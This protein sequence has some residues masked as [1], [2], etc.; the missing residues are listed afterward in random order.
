MT[1]ETV[2][3]SIPYLFEYLAMSEVEQKRWSYI[4]EHCS[5]INPHAQTRD[6]IINADHYAFAMRMH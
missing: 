6:V 4:M 3:V 1:A 5:Y 2:K